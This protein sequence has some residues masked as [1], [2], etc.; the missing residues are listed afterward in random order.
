MSYDQPQSLD[1]PYLYKVA[2]HLQGR[3][4]TGFSISLG[5]LSVDDCTGSSSSAGCNEWLGSG[6]GVDGSGR[7][8]VGS[9]PP[10]MNLPK[11]P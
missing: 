11:C 1:R 3:G 2:R 8:L 5:L 10:P 6:G 9:L 4:G 7:Y